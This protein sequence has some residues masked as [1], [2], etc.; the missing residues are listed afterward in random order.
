MIILGRYSF[1]Y[2]LRAKKVSPD[3]PLSSSVFLWV[4]NGEKSTQEN[5]ATSRSR[6]RGTIALPP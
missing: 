1:A 5:P 6:S 3:S 4:F 2:S